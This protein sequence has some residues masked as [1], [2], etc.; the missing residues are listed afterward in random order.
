[1][2]PIKILYVDDEA[3]A[4]KYFERLVSPIAPVLTAGSVQEG[5]AVLREHAA[6]IAVLVCDQRMPGEYG[7]ELLRHARQNYP[8]IVRMLTTAYS[9]LDEAIEAINTGEI[10]RYITKPWELESLR[11]DLK[12]AME[13]ADLRHER[14]ELM[15]DKLLAQQSQLLGNRLAALLMVSSAVVHSENDRDGE[16]E[17]ENALQQALFQFAQV[18]IAC[19]SAKPLLDWRHW[20]YADLLQAEAERGAS[21]AAHV[22]QWLGKFGPQRDDAHALSVLAQAAGGELQEDKLVFHDATPFT[23]LLT[24]PAGET[25]TAAQSAWLAWLLWQGGQ[26]QVEAVPGAWVVKRAVTHT[27]NLPQDWLADAIERQTAR[28]Y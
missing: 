1:M 11:A 4:L 5:R 15:R 20:E 18:A 3:M 13:L 14:D 26:A 23:A 2:K 12:N 25:A 17:R 27:Q 28:A 16:S 24:A 9:E 8:H 19:S 7:N 22:R 21:I 6:D 10:Y